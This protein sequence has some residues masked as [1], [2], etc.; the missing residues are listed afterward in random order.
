MHDKSITEN[1]DQ[2]N[3]ARVMFTID[4][5]NKIEILNL[6]VTNRETCKAM[7]PQLNDLDNI[8]DLTPNEVYRVRYH[9]K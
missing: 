1:S 3:K 8:S 4:K 9:F 5:N 6:S 2:L 7:K